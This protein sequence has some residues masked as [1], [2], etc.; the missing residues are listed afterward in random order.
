ML[1]RSNGFGQEF[2]LQ[3]LTF[4]VSL[5]MDRGISILAREAGW[6]L[7]SVLRPQRFFTEK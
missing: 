7:Q 1:Q 5:R 3:G 6:R 2:K 4:D